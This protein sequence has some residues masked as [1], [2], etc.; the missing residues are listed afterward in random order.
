MAVLKCWIEVVKDEP[1]NTLTVPNLLNEDGA[2]GRGPGTGA[3]YA[4]TYV[5]EGERVGPRS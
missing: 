2:F 5:Q 3:V 1:T 4:H